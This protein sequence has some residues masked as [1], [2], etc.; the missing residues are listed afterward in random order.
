[1]DIGGGKRVLMVGDEG[2]ALY[3]TTGKG[4]ERENSISWEVP[5]FEDQLTDALELQ[6]TAKSVLVLFDSADQA[7][8]NEEI[9]G[10][11]G[12]LNKGNFVKRKA[13]QLFPS[14]PIRAALEI[15]PTGKKRRSASDNVSYLFAALPENDRLDR[16]GQALLKSGVPISGFGL[17]PIE[18]SGLVQELAKKVFGTKQ[19]VK[20]GRTE[21]K[22]GSRWAAIIGQHETGARRQVFIKDGNLAFTRLTPTS[23]AGVSGAGWAEE[24]MQ[25]FKGTLAYISRI[26]YN[27]NDGLDLIVICGDIE[28]E[29][30][31]PKA[32]PVTNFKC[33]NTSEALRQLGVKSVGLEKTN[34]ADAVHA[35]WS[36][37]KS[38]LKL[39]IRVPSIHRIMAPRLTARVAS[40]MLVLTAL[41]AAYYTFDNY[42]T[43]RA[44]EEELTQSENQR[45]MLDREYQA[46]AKIFEEL[47][48]K[49]LE[50]KG[51]IAV[52][53]LLD[54]NTVPLAPLFNTLKGALGED[55]FLESITYKHTAVGASGLDATNSA[56]AIFAGAASA[57]DRGEIQVNFKFSLPMTMQLEQKV[58]RAETLEKALQ[59]A[60]PKLTVR[61]I[62]QFGKVDRQGKLEGQVGGESAAIGSALDDLAE[63]ELKGPPL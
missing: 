18:S 7:Y 2:V 53:K 3:A 44:F 38:V 39:P 12:A 63:I 59:T 61:I 4:M 41:G 62:S 31:D 43:Y 51:A 42:S 1:M 27:I 17:L 56:P 45:V 36:A 24:V 16:I 29:F 50:I 30:F 54:A 40:V 8:K 49:P 48:V 52:K 11:I 60:F 9:P 22:S 23:E 37:K 47:P 34:F 20:G 21:Q 6:N 10:T 14:H 26:G 57:D 58:T 46:E 55:I 25:E 5:N 13:M 35:A 19:K 28:K 32:M 33:M 15:K